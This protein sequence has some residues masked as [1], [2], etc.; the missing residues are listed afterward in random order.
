MRLNLFNLIDETVE[1]LESELDNLKTIERSI[2]MAMSH[3]LQSEKESLLGIQSRIKS[4]ESLREKMIRNRYYVYYTNAQEVFQ[5]LSDVI[6]VRIECRFLKDEMHLVE[7]LRTLFTEGE[8]SFKHAH[9]Y[10]NIFLD[11]HSPQ[12]QKQ[13][14]GLGIIRIDGYFIHESKKVNFELQIK[15]LVNSFWGSIEH[16]LVYKNKHYLDVDDFMSDM[17]V[18][19]N[20]S[21]NVLDNQL[22]IIYNQIQ[23]LSRKDI[24]MNEKNIENLITKAINDLFST[25]MQE[26]LGFSLSIKYTSK[27]IASYLFNKNVLY[28]IN[29][30]DRIASL[31]KVLRK[32]SNIVI[33]FEKEIMFDQAYQ[34]HNRF[35]EIFGTYLL[36]QMNLDYDWYIFFKML[37]EIEAGTNLMN[38]THFVETMQYSLVDDYFMNTSFVHFTKDNML[39]AQEKMWELLA[40]S[41]IHANSSHVVSNATVTDFNKIF[42]QFVV[43]VEYECF[44]YEDLIHR[45][46][47]YQQDWNKIAYQI[48]D[49]EQ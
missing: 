36:Q 21:L 14:N 49:K 40:N 8:G 28:T 24:E 43:I 44:T 20:Q 42:R 48:L 7:K 33:D 30:E 25:K 38:F 22:N 19:I 27:L 46:D 18:S 11:I 3:L 2:V 23:H 47:E 5:H 34:P 12:P 10:P 16:R 41:L 31:L 35:Q 9:G 45:L 37:F 39:L 17:L 29:G 15:S 13:K 4:K 26:N 6:G 1:V 32:T